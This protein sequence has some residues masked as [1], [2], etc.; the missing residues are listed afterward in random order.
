MRTVFSIILLTTQAFGAFSQE[1][2]RILEWVDT[3][4]K[5]INCLWFDGED[6]PNT[7][8]KVPYYTELIPLPDSKEYRIEITQIKWGKLHRDFDSSFALVEPNPT[9]KNFNVGGSRLMLFSIPAMRKNTS[10]SIEKLESFRF[11]IAPTSTQKKN[12]DK[13]IR[14]PLSNS[15]LATGKWVKVGVQKSG[16]YKITYEDL[17]KYGFSNPEN[18][19]IW[20]IGGKSL[21]LMNAQSNLDEITPIPI[22]VSKGDDGIFNQGDF[23]L[24]YAQ[25]PETLTY[26]ET[27]SAWKWEKHGYTKTIYYFLTTSQPQT[28]ID[29]ADTPTETE[30]YA[31]SEFDQVT[32]FERNDTNLVKSGREWFGEIFDLKTTYSYNVSTPLPVNNSNYKV[33]VR[34]AARSSSTSTF[35]LTNSGTLGSI[36]LNPVIIG[37]ELTNVVSVNNK[38]FSGNTAGQNL[39][40][41]LTYNK[42]NSG[43]V[44]FLDFISIQSRHSLSYNGAQ[45]P[46]QDFQSVGAG[47][48]SR[49]TIS[50]A[51]SSV[52][53]WDVTNINKAKR[54]NISYANGTI[55]FKQ[56]TDTIKTFIAFEP[57]MAYSVVSYAS[58]DNQ[59]I[60]GSGFY[61]YFIVTHPSFKTY[62][63]ELAQLHR[64][65][66]NISVAV[67]T[68]DEVYNEF[69]SGNPDVAAIRNMMRYFYKAA[70]SDDDKPKYLLLFGDG[71]YD[72]LS[73]K[74]ENT[75]YVLTYQSPR[76][77]NR[78]ESFVS[79][80]F[81][82]LLDDNEG[83]ATGYIDIGIGRLPVSS[84]EQ[85]A[86][87]V[88]K[89][90]SY[91]ED[92]EIDDWH[93]KLVFI[94]DDEDGNVHMQD[95]NTLAKYIETN[96]PAYNIQK[97]FFDA[98]QQ[99]VGSGGQRYPDVTNAI[100]SAINNGAL[101]VNYTGH[102]NERWLA[103]EKVLTL[104]DVLGWKN[105]KR[106][107]L[108]VTATCEFSRFDDYHLTSTGE[109][110]LLNPSGGAVALLST[111]RLVYSSPNFTLNYNFI[112]QLFRTDTNG[113]YFRLGD[114]VRITKTLSG[115]GYNKRNFTLLGDPAL[116][117][118]YPTY[119]IKVTHINERPT[120]E[121]SDTLKA[122]NKASIKGA[123]T[124][125][126]DTTVEDFNGIVSV[127]L[128]DKESEITTLANDGGT[129]M[130]FK[131]RNS[132]IFK[133]RA[134][135]SQG[136]FSIDF[137]IPKDINYSYGHG[138]ISLF[139]TN[140]T[141][142]ALGVHDSIV[143]GGIGNPESIDSEGPQINIYLND[144]KF[145]NGGI[146][147]S[148]PL[149]LVYLSDAS[150]IN[151]T[152][153]GIG[154]DLTAKL[155]YPAG[156]S[157][158]F[159]L[160][161]F[162]KANTDD[163]TQGIAT[164]QFS[165]L[166]PGTYTIEVK[167]WDAFNNSNTGTI[168]FRVIGDDKL[169]VSNFY[170]VPNPI[171]DNAQ[172]YFET[173]TNET[174]LDVKLE[175]FNINGS[176]VAELPK[177][178]IYTEGY[179]IGPLEWNGCNSNGAKLAKGIYFARIHVT[180][181]KGEQVATT[182]IV[183]L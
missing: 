163:Y 121:P 167:A 129:P 157:E 130:T 17:Q 65:R 87:V 172:F 29:F 8:S 23:I 114:L 153:S 138:K 49:F 6:F 159:N 9:T 78:V 38:V 11:K 4:K 171:K 68:T 123:I 82:G 145:T 115:T 88:A 180:S 53:V 51:N 33:W 178:R 42:P 19:S 101:L 58:V 182:K 106:L 52:Q 149:L 10:G 142:T 26:N 116:M 77:I 46:F 12:A 102:G 80:D 126:L 59:N 34:V 108:F 67:H 134:S 3:D 125:N 30:N 141:Q 144:T 181:V 152:G 151:T 50:N 39:T 100:N 148:N 70:T 124:D 117:L 2:Y 146:C 154:H 79:D 41:D 135:V 165:G 132:I 40:F 61:D 143:V 7:T 15:V 140:G 150:G 183:I 90:K 48:I 112:Q 118:K 24:F 75:N 13:M 32:T 66:S 169:V 99:E 85:A 161:N 136:T 107:P 25:G 173:N 179:R 62:A 97:I 91:M 73:N 160:N 36:S 16:I 86:N 133:G 174:E 37:N 104:N 18:I 128:Y 31:T 54:V 22:L 63:E 137:T 89:I 14:S 96:Y 35:T 166:N 74:P 81:F 76:S 122:L 164:Y 64:Q 57:D 94:G 5:N 162:Y 20:G 55:T 139:A 113:N 98:Y 83:E 176:K 110:I 147:N 47:R 120:S 45:L 28:L 60:R 69:S 1:F 156:Q 27:F 71:S 21:P 158:T 105:A 56:P 93:S 92:E 72:N 127:T 168:R 109:W 131:S 155:T 119:N 44:G 103:H 84:P 175:I 111:T 170:C 177:K 95:A 43:S